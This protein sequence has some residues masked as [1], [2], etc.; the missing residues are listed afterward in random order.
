MHIFACRTEYLFYLANKKMSYNFSQCMG[1]AI[2]ANWLVNLAIW[3][4][5][6][7]QVC[8]ADFVV[9]H[10]DVFY[11]VCIVRCANCDQSHSVVCRM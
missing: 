8:A 11:A 2:I 7:A 10:C 6:A 3:I 1:R 4:A 5:N 9:L